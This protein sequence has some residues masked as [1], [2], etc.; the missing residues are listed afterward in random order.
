MKDMITKE[1]YRRIKKIPKASLNAR[2]TIQ[3]INAR[4]VLIIMTEL[5]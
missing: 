4:A 3:P 5:E 2:N 1:Y